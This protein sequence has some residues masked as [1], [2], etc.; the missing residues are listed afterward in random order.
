[1]STEEIP[2]DTPLLDQVEAALH[3]LETAI[4][5]AEN[6]QVLKDAILT[7]HHKVEGFRREISEA[8]QSSYDEAGTQIESRE[9]LQNRFRSLT[10]LKTLGDKTFEQTITYWRILLKMRFVLVQDNDP[11]SL[12][13]IPVSLADDPRGTEPDDSDDS[14]SVWEIPD[15]DVPLSDSVL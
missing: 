12:P 15:D 11:L 3:E 1:M 14:E 8:L 7:I 13:A 6:I 2:S 4:Q 10:T 5:T 9:Y